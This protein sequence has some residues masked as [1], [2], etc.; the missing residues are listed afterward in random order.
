MAPTCR[1]ERQLNNTP[2]VV[3]L[4]PMKHW[5][6]RL[7]NMMFDLQARADQQIVNLIHSKLELGLNFVA[8]AEAE[9]CAYAERSFER[10]NQSFAEVQRLLP[11]LNQ[12]QRQDCGPTL[13]SLQEALDRFGRN[14]DRHRQ[15]FPL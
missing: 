6:R 7:R 1:V 10:A 11:A 13:N 14:R 4:I 12:D 2:S 3:Q 5:E 15:Q 9:Q 8:L